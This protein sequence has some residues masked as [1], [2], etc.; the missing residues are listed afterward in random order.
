MVDRCSQTSERIKKETADGGKYNLYSMKYSDHYDLDKIISLFTEYKA[1]LA[2]I[3]AAAS[4]AVMDALEIHSANKIEFQPF[5][6]TAFKYEDH[7]K[8]IVRMGRNYDFKDNTSCMMV[9]CDPTKT[10]PGT[11][12]SIAF[13]ALSNIGIADPTLCKDDE[14]L[15]MAPFICLDGIN[16]AGVSI[17]V[18]VVDGEPTYQTTP[19]NGGQPAEQKQDIFT[20]LAIRLVL[21]KA[22]TVGEAT[23]ILEKYN[24][25]ATG[26]KDYHFFITDKNGDSVVVEY[27][28]KDPFRQCHIT[29]ANI[30]TN[31]YLFN[32]SNCFGHGHDRYVAVQKTLEY[33]SPVIK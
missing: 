30:V 2:N 17:A 6:C 4:K 16:D 12:R 18:L 1:G 20:T 3:D 28:Y 13:A 24:M 31:F 22:G 23:E 33:A 15:L 19:S 10:K 14:R 29:N 8:K 25:F 26:T 7:A 11:H 27:D 9:Y 21:D 32:G 5:G